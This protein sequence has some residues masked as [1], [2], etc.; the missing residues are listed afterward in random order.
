MR[1]DFRLYTVDN[2]WDIDAVAGMPA[3]VT[4][5]NELFQRAHVAA[6]LQKGSIPLLEDTGNDWLK[7]FMHEVSFTELDSQIRQNMILLT[8]S[9]NFVPAY[10]ITGDAMSLTVTRV[11]VLRSN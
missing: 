2:Y 11:D 9:H 1:V 3:T 8:E 7:Y 10:N 5:D 4:G 6:F